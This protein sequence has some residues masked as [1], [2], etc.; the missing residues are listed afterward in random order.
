MLKIGEFSKVSKTTIKAL[1]FYDK[2]GLFKPYKIDDNG[3]RYYDISQ[4]DIL[5]KIVEYRQFGFSIKEIKTLL[6]TD[7]LQEILCAHL[8]KMRLQKQTLEKNI[9]SLT[10]KINKGAIMKKYQIIEKVI[11]DYNVYY[12]HGIISSMDKLAEF[13]YEAGTEASQNNPDLRCLDYCYV[14]YTAKEYKEKNIELEYI[15]AVDGKVNESKN[16]KSKF[17]KGGKFLSVSH[18]GSYDGLASA[19]SYLLNYIKEKDF[20]ISGDI[21]EVY[22]DGCWN[23][24]NVEDYLTEIQVPIA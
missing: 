10:K 2:V 15:E 20:E 3:Y 7:N 19:Y 12:R 8:Q 18:K 21:R 4:L 22:I 5:L 16:I 23:K 17:V 13:V 24:E 1:R 9:D 14:T 11:P 6:S